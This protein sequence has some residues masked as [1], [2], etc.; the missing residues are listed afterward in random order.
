[1]LGW[2]GNVLE[3]EFEEVNV[4][5][6]YAEIFWHIPLCLLMCTLCQRRLSLTGPQQ[7]LGCCHECL[8]SAF[9]HDQFWC[10]AGQVR[11]Y[12]E[13]GKYE[14]GGDLLL[15]HCVSLSGKP[16]IEFTRRDLMS[17]KS[18]VIFL[19]SGRLACILLLKKIV[20]CR[21]VFVLN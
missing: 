13:V 6:L 15:G 7:Q 12:V 18:M 1:M 10:I 20:R 4:V 9:N 17:L 11:P 21:L 3:V 19:G 5:V 16:K 8:F 2:L 14:A